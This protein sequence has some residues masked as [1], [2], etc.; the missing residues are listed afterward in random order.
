MSS[1]FS[2]WSCEDGADERYSCDIGEP[3]VGGG[4]DSDDAIKGGE[5]MAFILS[6]FP[7]RNFILFGSYSLFMLIHPSRSHAV[8]KVKVTWPASANGADA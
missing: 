3:H 5:A 7:A 6:L 2:E 4:K 8:T 1:N